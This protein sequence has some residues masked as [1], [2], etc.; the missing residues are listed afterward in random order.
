[1][2]WAH[3]CSAAV[4]EGYGQSYTGEVECESAVTGRRARLGRGVQNPSCKK[5]S[6]IS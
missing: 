6:Y 3:G 1:M 2:K 4:G 5:N